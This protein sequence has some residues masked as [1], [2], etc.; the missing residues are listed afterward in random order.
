[1]NKLK[2]ASTKRSGFTLIELV[3]VMALWMI[4]MAGAS[5]LL[6]H[7][8]SS[9]TRMITS[10]GALESARVAKDFLTVNIQMADTIILQRDTDGMLRRLTLYQIDQNGRRW[11]YVFT[12]NRTANRLQFSTYNELA[13]HISEV[14]LAPSSNNNIMDIAITTDPSIGEPITVTSKVDIRFKYLEVR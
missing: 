3:V 8:T 13:P 10:Q 1:M 5:H 2:S 6:L 11:P 9:S 4:L 7:S 12:Y 14:R